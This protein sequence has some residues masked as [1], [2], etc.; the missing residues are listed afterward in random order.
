MSGQQNVLKMA[1]TQEIQK[2]SLSGIDWNKLTVEEFHKLHKEMEQRD[3]DIKKMKPR[4][5]RT[6]ND[7]VPFEIRGEIYMVK[8]SVIEKY[9]KMRSEKSRFK[10]L[11][12]V[13]ET[14]R[15]IEEV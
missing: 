9:K 4:K 14:C 12:Q 15:R 5:K 11:K 7:E 13:R 3:A 2:I 1:Q 6:E 8:A 10:L